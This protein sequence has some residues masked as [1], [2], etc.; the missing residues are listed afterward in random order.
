MLDQD[1]WPLVA[2]SV[3]TI[4]LAVT[5]EA[6]I[7]QATG[8]IETAG[9][10]VELYNW[11]AASKLDPADKFDR[12]IAIKLATGRALLKAG[13]QLIRQANGRVKNIDDNKKQSEIQKAERKV[14][15]KKAT[16][17]R[18]RVLKAT[19]LKEISTGE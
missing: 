16:G 17:V 7:A 8:L 19:K 9:D 15:P 14:A 1:K 4:E 11:S 13:N 18:A 5:R 2:D 12:E 10:G 3:I 6:T